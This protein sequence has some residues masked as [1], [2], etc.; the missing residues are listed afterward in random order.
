MIAEWAAG[1][2]KQPKAETTGAQTETT[3]RIS[4]TQAAD[5]RTLCADNG[6]PV[7]N[8]C[9]AAKVERLEDIATLDLPRA[10][11]WVNS[12]IERRQHAGANS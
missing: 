3:T 1:G 4:E 10:S 8:L 7:E 2:T 12:A 6:I 9:K 5:L 11:T